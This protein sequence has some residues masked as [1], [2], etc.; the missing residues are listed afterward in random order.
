M[1]RSYPRAVEPSAAT[2]STLQ[3]DGMGVP[4]QG[5]QCAV[6]R[7]DRIL[8][9]YC[10]AA[11]TTINSPDLQSHL[12]IKDECVGSSREPTSDRVNKRCGAVVI[13]TVAVV[14]PNE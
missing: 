6:E 1:T 10:R 11:R 12:K 7:V 2:R 9:E 5:A 14:S 8:Y 13:G 4:C 3:F